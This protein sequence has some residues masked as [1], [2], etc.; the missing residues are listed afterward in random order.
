EPLYGRNA[1]AVDM[2]RVLQQLF[3]VTDL[4]DMHLRPELILLQRTMVTVEGVARMLDPTINMWDAAAPVV[5]DYLQHEIGPRKQA[6]RLR[7]AAIKAAEIAP[8]L[9]DYVETIAAAASHISSDSVRLSDQS[10][11][12]IADAI[13]RKNRLERVA[14]WLI[15]A[16]ALILSAALF[17][18]QI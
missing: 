9:P 16:A 8:R 3:D 11:A 17:V 4:F 2:S 14:L 15:G 5:R 6:E 13:A 7:G 18:R 10:A 1:E 12:T